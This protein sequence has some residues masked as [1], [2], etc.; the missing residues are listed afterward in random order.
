[1]KVRECDIPKTT[2]RTRYVHYE[3]FVIS[4]GLTNAHAVFLDLMNKI[5]KPYLDIFV[6]VLIDD[7]LIYSRN[8][9]VHSIHLRI[10]L[11]TSRDKELYVKFP[12]CEFWV[13][14]VAFLG[15]IVSGE[16]IRVD[17]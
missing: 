5:F 6:I 16:G 12:E 2:F 8:E 17:T 1:M 9:K 10:V 4:F 3:F 11:Q 7:I 15:H 13:K 14:Y